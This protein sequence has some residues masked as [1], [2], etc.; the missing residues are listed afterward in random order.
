M[1]GATRFDSS[2][3]DAEFCRRLTLE[4]GV[5]AVPISA[6]Y[7]ERDVRSHIRFCFAKTRETLGTALVR[8]ARWNDRARS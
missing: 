3:D 8:L 7:G 5:T 6:F 1:A 4:A 2:G